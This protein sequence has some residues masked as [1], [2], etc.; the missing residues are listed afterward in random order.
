M[1]ILAIA[2]II[3]ARFDEYSFPQ[4]TSKKIQELE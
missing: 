3:D 4:I 2:K 1:E